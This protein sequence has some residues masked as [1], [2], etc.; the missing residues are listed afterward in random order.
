MENKNRE[1][2]SGKT[3]IISGSSKGIGKVLARELGL[4]GANI[5]LNGTNAENLANTSKE[6]LGMGIECTAVK[7]NVAVMNDCRRMAEIALKQ[8]GSIDAVIANAGLT[9]SGSLEDSNVEIF[10]QLM[11]VNYAGTVYL[12]KACLPALKKSMGSILITGSASGFRGIPGN[13]AYCASKMA[14]T[15]LADALKI[16]LFKTNIH[17]GIA[18]VGFTENDPDKTML[19]TNGKLVIKEKIARGPVASQ[20]AV[21]LQMIS[22]I[23]H[24]TFKKNFSFLGKV[25]ALVVRFAPWLGDIILKNHY[26]KT[27]DSKSFDKLVEYPFT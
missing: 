9:T 16:E 23:R 11:D 22:M 8:Y 1:T 7:G 20:R 26:F 3:I 18:Y 24:R 5:I 10:K 21:A 15:A 2:F 14:L 4:M 13:A 17:V 19:D 12:I 6:L 25:N 27:T